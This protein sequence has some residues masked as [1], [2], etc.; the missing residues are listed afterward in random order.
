MGRDQQNE[1]QQEA[2]RI[3]T[4]LQCQDEGDGVEMQQDAGHST[5]KATDSDETPVVA[6]TYEGKSGC[7]RAILDE[8]A[9]HP[10]TCEIDVCVKRGADADAASVCSENG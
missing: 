6:A 7:A 3:E 10:C 5:C 4:L 2:H 9:L 8:A 1:A